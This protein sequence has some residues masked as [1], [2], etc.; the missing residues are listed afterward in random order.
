MPR[1]FYKHMSD[2]APAV[3]GCNSAPRGLCQRGSGETAALTPCPTP[4]HVTL[5]P[6]SVTGV[7]RRELLIPPALAKM[8]LAS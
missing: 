3:D 7:S 4:M 2:C 1:E 5:G 8:C 6:L